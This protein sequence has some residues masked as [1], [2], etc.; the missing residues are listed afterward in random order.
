MALVGPTIVTS[1]VAMSPALVPHSPPMLVTFAFVESGNAA[2]APLTLVIV[3]PGAAPSNVYVSP[4]NV[5]VS[6]LPAASLMVPVFER[7]RRVVGLA[8]GVPGPL[9]ALTVYTVAGPA[10]GVIAS[11]AGEPP[12]PVDW[13][14]KLA[15]PTL[16]TGSLNVTA[17]RTVPNAWGFGS[18]RVIETTVGRVASTDHV[19]VAGALCAVP[20][21]A[22]TRNV[23]EPSASALYETV[24]VLPAAA[25]QAT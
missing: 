16:T 18:S 15:R 24:P 22:S 13:S 21:L 12:R 17:Q 5:A 11:S 19:R 7:S 9:V 23:W 1:T 25:G 6:V 8:L 4:L 2:I 10:F 20:T 3:T 14:E